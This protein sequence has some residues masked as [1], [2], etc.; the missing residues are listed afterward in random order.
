MRSGLEQVLGRLL[1]FANLAVAIASCFCVL[2]I[3]AAPDAL[4]TAAGTTAG[5]FRIAV[6]GENGGIGMLAF[7][8]GM[9][10]VLDVLWMAWG[11]APR[12][13]SSTVVSETDNGPVRVSKDALESGLRA[14]GEALD[15]VSRLRI[16]VDAPRAR[17]KRVLVRALFQAREGARLDV[18]SHS[19]REAL[20]ARFAELVRLAPHAR[21]EL[22]LEFGGFLGR[23]PRAAEAA[24]KPTEEEESPPFTGPR[25][26]IDNDD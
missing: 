1:L 6:R 18:V 21:L 8:A 10:L 7:A 13:P 9:M 20:R 26:P 16:Q 23:A 11:L 19:L 25:Y 15:D 3:W 12:G 2:L 17:G 14:A 4:S 24:P 5:V 22:E